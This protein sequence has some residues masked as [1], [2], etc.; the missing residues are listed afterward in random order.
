MAL[1]DDALEALAGA[2][3]DDGRTWGETATAWQWDLV[4][5]VL[6]P[7]G[8]V[9]WWSVEPR[10]ARKTT[11]AALLLLILLLFFAPTE[12]RLF[13]VAGDEQ[14]A[15]EL[16]D[17]ARGIVSRTP[18]L[19]GALSFSGLRVTNPVTGATVEALAS[20]A[21]SAFGRRPWAI[22][23]DEVTNWA[24]SRGSRAMWDAMVSAAKKVPGCRL[25][26]ISNAGYRSHWS[27]KRWEV[28]RASSH[29][30]TREIPG[31]LPWLSVGDVE[32]LRENSTSPSE[33]ER[34]TLGR[35]VSGDDG[36]ADLDDLLVCV[37]HDGVLPPQRGVRYVAGLD[38]GLK[39]DRT[40]LV[41]GHREPSKPVVIDLLRRWQG[42]RL[43]PV[44]LADVEAAIVDVHATYGP[45][46]LH[47]DP[48]QAAAM[49]QRLRGVGVPV[50]E[51]AFTSSSVGRIASVLHRL[52]RD[53]EIDLP[54]DAVLI[55]ELSRVRLVTNSQ[56]VVRLGHDAGQHDDQAVAIGLVAQALVSGPV[57]SVARVGHARGR[58]PVALGQ[59]SAPS[60]RA[61]H[62][63]PPDRA[64][65]TVRSHFARARTGGNF[66]PP[67]RSS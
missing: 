42:T 52:I 57:S 9:Q 12:A 19:S 2:V 62:I 49:T 21:G 26:V 65:E 31:P 27:F 51:Y 61:E 5:R 35:W 56:G 64:G 7:E 10:G 60:S 23:V 3:M 15:A 38:L 54:D 63:A 28:A 37:G 16:I 58:V 66:R 14:Q 18:G 55:D 32:S 41:V 36:L 40:V 53:R 20:D 6:S 48:W 39:N 44:D 17:A 33:F 24:D 13:V 22:V 45:S 43:R 30:W 46:A 25:L 11:T 34:L 8:V 1:V 4:R 47:F 67:G 59:A 29:W 50:S